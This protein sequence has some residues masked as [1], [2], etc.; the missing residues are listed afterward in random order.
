MISAFA[1]W[2]GAKASFATKYVNRALL[3]LDPQR[4]TRIRFSLMPY[5]ESRFLDIR[6][7]PVADRLA[8]LDDFVAA[9]YQVHLNFSP[10]VLSPGWQDRWS[11]LLDDLDDTTGE[12]FKGQAAAEIIMLTHNRDL[13]QVNLGWHP[14]AENVLWTPTTQQPKKSQN[15]SWNVRYRN[16]IKAAAVAE[17]TSMI[18][19]KTPWL[20]IRYAF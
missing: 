11:A 2:E 1:G 15:G 7:S 20:T 13:H 4:G 9:G 16:D 3:D 14:K 8:A 18:A 12:N 6:T 17:L 5:A 10:V 19:S